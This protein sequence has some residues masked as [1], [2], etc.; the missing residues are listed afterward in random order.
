MIENIYEEALSKKVHDAWMEEK[1]NQGFTYGETLDLV[2]KKH[3]DML[4]YEELPENVKEYDRA[5]VRAVL[6]AQREVRTVPTLRVNTIYPAFMGEVNSYGIGAM[7][8]F[9]RLSGCNLRCYYKTKGTL[10]DTPEALSIKS[11]KDMTVGEIVNKVLKIKNSLLCLTGGE[12]LMQNVH[13]L[14]SELTNNGCH[15]VIE[16]NGSV[17]LEPYRHFREVSF[18]VDVKTSSSG[19]SERMIERNYELLNEKD[20][21]KFVIDTE[22][23]FEEFV[24]W[25][26][27]H[28]WITC[29]VAVGLFWGSKLSYAWLIKQLNSLRYHTCLNMQTH[30]M[31]CL[32]D[33][34]KDDETFS[35]LIIPREL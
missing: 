29:N 16:T 33:K 21:V 6:K 30:K 10:C 14:L 17:G 8:T 2:N 26:V 24:N 18:V 23:D 20:Y 19:E 13:Q 7:A 34:H 35:E 1:A 25:R 28:N 11:G 9:V 27:S 32:Y 22:K 12:P 15:V 4:P 5:T 31:A 3:P